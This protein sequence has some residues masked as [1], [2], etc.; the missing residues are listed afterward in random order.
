MS[1]SNIDWPF[2][3]LYVYNPVIGC[4][5]GCEYCW[6]EKFWKRFTEVPFDTLRFNLTELK[7][8]LK[9]CTF[10][11]SEFTDPWYWK[12]EWLIKIK[13]LI[14]KRM[15][16]N[17]IILTKNFWTYKCFE[18]PLNTILGYTDTCE[19]KKDV[20]FFTG[21]AETRKIMFSFEPL[22]GPVT[23]KI[24]DSAIVIVGGM[25]YMGKKNVPVKKEWIDSI[26]DNYS[27]EIYFKKNVQ[28]FK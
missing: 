11:I 2:P 17:F 21:L 6:A 16:Q 22:L 13:E 27:G 23:Y 24:P 8:K 5:R 3:D 10:F 25:N 28:H 20:S 4:I 15:H 7:P 9:P 12:P 19:E 18:F 14:E 26:R 1:K